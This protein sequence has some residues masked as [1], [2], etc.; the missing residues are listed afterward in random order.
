MSF[1]EQ[2]QWVLL[3]SAWI[4]STAYSFTLQ[5]RIK[6][7]EERLA[8]L[9]TAYK[10]AIKLILT[11]TKKRDEHARALKRLTDPDSIVEDMEKGARMRE[12]HDANRS[13]LPRE[14]AGPPAKVYSPRLRAKVPKAT[15]KPT[16][17]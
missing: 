17:D 3:C 4:G 9:S 1:T 8:A 13:L 5:N 14:D 15:N 10:A 6:K 11:E 7:N 2:M 12:M 16:Q